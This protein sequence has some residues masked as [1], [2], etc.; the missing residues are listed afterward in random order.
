MVAML[1]ATYS[2][3]SVTVASKCTGVYKKDDVVVVVADNNSVFATCFYYF[4]NVAKC[5]FM[6]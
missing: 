1:L 4:D 2:L 6:T 5:Y 3:L